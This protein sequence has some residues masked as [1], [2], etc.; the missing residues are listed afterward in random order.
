MRL[1]APAVRRPTRARARNLNSC[2]DVGSLT[3]PI[4]VV[5]ALQAIPPQPKTG[6]LELDAPR[7]AKSNPI[8]AVVYTNE[9][10]SRQTKVG[11]PAAAFNG[12]SEIVAKTRLL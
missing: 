9:Q 6:P 12:S 10:L 2:D 4:V 8:D 1:I 3:R 11:L 5:F 7:A